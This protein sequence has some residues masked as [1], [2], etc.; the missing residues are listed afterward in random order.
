MSES[1]SKSQW[2][3]KFNLQSKENELVVP[4]K[5]THSTREDGKGNVLEMTL[6]DINRDMP[7]GQENVETSSI[8][9]ESESAQG[10][11]ALENHEENTEERPPLPPR[12]ILLQAPGRPKTSHSIER[13]SILL[14]KPTTALSSVDIQTLSFPDGS[15]GTFS[16]PAKS[17]ASDSAS[18]TAGSS[19]PKLSRNGSEIDDNASLMSYT[20]TMRA[21]GDL[22]SLLDEGLS[23]QSAAWKLL[24]SQAESV[25]PFESIEYQ[26]E[27]LVDFEKEFDEL[28]AVTSGN[29]G[30][31]SSGSLLL[32]ILISSQRMSWCSGGRNSNTI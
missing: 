2:Y 14:S 30:E 11:E 17:A 4:A 29:E 19:T 26:D 21:N 9:V 23:S 31:T 8:S 18:G 6:D 7:K 25:N 12:P 20:P 22:A 24:S 5:A 27:S 16:T 1:A 10:N 32:S 28:A 13:P 15:R 3:P